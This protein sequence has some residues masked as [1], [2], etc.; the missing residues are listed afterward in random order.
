M[1]PTHPDYRFRRLDPPDDFARMAELINLNHEA[2]GIGEATTV[3]SVEHN[4]RHL[5]NCDP[6]TDMILADRDGTLMGYTRADWWQVVNGPRVHAVFVFVHPSARSSGL[7]ELLFDWSETRNREM[8]AGADLSDTVFQGWAE[9]TKQPWLSTIYRGRGYTPITYGAEMV[10]PHLDRIPEA[11]LPDGVEIRPVA[12]S[13]LRVIWEA[14]NRA[15]RDHWGYSERSETDYT[16]Y[17]EFPHRDETLWQVAW[18][19]DSV[20]GQVRPFIDHEENA[21]LGR[22]RGYVEFIS[23]APEWRKRGVATAL[24]CAAMRRLRDRGM[25]E[26]ALGVH[27]ENPTGAFELYTSLGFELVSRYSTFQKPMVTGFE[28]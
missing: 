4:Y 8:A 10:R 13:H 14:D 15:F 16:R 22:R 19:G 2:D 7:G 21:R 18:H 23:T 28:P 25:T 17:L 5:E 20:V 26:G 11:A 1:L 24:I 27:T 9:E 3:E 6:A 12:P